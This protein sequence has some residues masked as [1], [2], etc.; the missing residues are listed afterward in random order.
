MTAQELFGKSYQD[1][2]QM[3]NSMSLDE[4]LDRKSKMDA[5]RGELLDRFEQNKL[6]PQERETLDLLCE[7]LEWE[8]KSAIR[9]AKAKAPDG[10]L[11]KAA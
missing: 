2:I 9:K 6:T 10:S 7:D 4:L 5:M 8:M 3:L 11:R 1:R